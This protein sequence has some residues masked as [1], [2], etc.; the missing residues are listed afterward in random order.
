MPKIKNIHRNYNIEKCCNNM[1]NQYLIL[2]TIFATIISEEIEND[3]DLGI[4]GSFL[5]TLGEELALASEIRIACKEK[6]EHESSS[7]EIV[8]DIFD[9]SSPIRTRKVKKIKRKYVRRDK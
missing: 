1:A 7:E 8:E 2:V 6:L 3:E 5:I 9:R 4:L